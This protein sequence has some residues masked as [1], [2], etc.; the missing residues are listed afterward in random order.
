MGPSREDIQEY[1][2]RKRRKRSAPN[3]VPKFDI[4]QFAQGRNHPQFLIRSALP[5]LTV[6]ALE[7][8]SDDDE[9]RNARERAE[10]AELEEELGALA[11]ELGEPIQD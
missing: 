2:K 4:T 7:E 5:S 11:D 10:L 9:F 3:R 8:A 6:Y 1:R